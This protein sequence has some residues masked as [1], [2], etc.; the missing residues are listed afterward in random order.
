[1]EGG[2]LLLLV[3]LAEVRLVG[4]PLLLLLLLQLRARLLLLLE[5]GL[6]H[7]LLLVL[8]AELLEVR[9]GLSRLVLHGLH[10]ALLLLQQLLLCCDLIPLG[11]LLLLELGTLLLLLELLFMCMLDLFLQ[12]L[13]GVHV[14]DDLLLRGGLFLEELPVPRADPLVLL[15]LLLA[16]LNQLLVLFAQ[17]LEDLLFRKFY[18]FLPLELENGDL[19]SEDLDLLSLVLLLVAQPLHLLVG[20]GH[21]G[22][23]CSYP[24]DLGVGETDGR[25]DV[26]GLLENLVVGLLALL[27]E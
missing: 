22:L 9:L 20:L 3:L 26:G 7:L 10:S 25:P 23:E 24:L 14:L 12:L 11:G 4:A 19:V 2:L 27:Y 6:L 5:A 1:M 16:L 8:P 18:V 21:L 17:L 13:S 15:I